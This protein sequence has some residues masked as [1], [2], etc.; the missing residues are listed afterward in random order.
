MPDALHVVCSSDIR[1]RIA[2]A[3]VTQAIASSSTPRDSGS[4]KK[5]RIASP[6]YLSIVAPWASAICDISVR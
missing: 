6:T 3:I 1:L 2:R 4:P 5:T